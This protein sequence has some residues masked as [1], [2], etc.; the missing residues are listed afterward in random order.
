MFEHIFFPWDNEYNTLRN[1]FSLRPKQDVIIRTTDTYDIETALD[2]IAEKKL[3]VTASNGKH[4]T[5]LLTPNVLIDMTRMKKIKFKDDENIIS[6]QGGV[7][8]GEANDFFLNI[9][10]NYHLPL[11]KMKHP[12]THVE[13]VNGGTAVSIGLVSICSCG[14]VSTLKRSLNLTCDSAVEFIITVPPDK[15]INIQEQSELMKDRDGLRRF[16]PGIRI[17]GCRHCRRPRPRGSARRDRA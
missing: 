8:Q 13:L 16:C 11:G 1:Y 17:P 6:V 14:G 3:T 5:L 7:T 10:D 9:S 2:Y 12:N 4:S 15:H